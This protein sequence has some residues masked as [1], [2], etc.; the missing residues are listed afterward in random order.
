MIILR[1]ERAPGLYSRVY[2]LVLDRHKLCPVRWRRLD[3]RGLQSS[4]GFHRRGVISR[5]ALTVPDGG[6]HLRAGLP[7]DVGRDNE[8]CVGSLCIYENLSL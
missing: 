1:H 6:H 3:R 5:A 2:L 7:Q 4:A 8:T